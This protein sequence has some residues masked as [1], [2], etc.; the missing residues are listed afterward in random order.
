MIR[1]LRKKIVSVTMATL[2]PVILVA[3]LFSSYT[4]KK[5]CGHVI[6]LVVQQMADSGGN[7][8]EIETINDAVLGGLQIGREVLLPIVDIPI[9]I[10]TLDRW[11]AVVSVTCLT[12]E[13]ELAEETLDGILKRSEKSGS[14][15]WREC[16]YAKA[17]D[18]QGATLVIA[19]KTDNL[20]KMVR[21]K[22]NYYMLLTSLPGVVVLLLASWIFSGLAMRPAKEALEKQQQF[23]AD[24]GHELKTPLASIAVNAAALEEN[25]GRNRYLDCI[26][27]EN[28][29]LSWLVRRM[30]AAACM[31]GPEEI[32]LTQ[33]DLTSLLEQAALSY[34]AAAME[35]QIRYEFQ[36]QDD[37]SVLSDPERL[38]Q[39][40]AILLDNA[41]K[42]VDEAG[43][44]MVSLYKKGNHPVIAVGNSGPG[45]PEGD[46]PHIFDRFYRVDKARSATDSHGLGLSIASYLVRELRG[47]LSVESDPGVWTEFLLQL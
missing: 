44:V 8:V 23:L 38:R 43:T 33:V 45:I 31:E 41:F 6:D 19:E 4:V 30:I 39:I 36:I 25:I 12:G 27:Y 29:R 37:V 10:V 1:R 18:E 28:N 16:R 47:K 5:T 15:E 21:R 24:A 7:I 26:R 22:M 35:R 32:T 9:H 3:V 11:D 42:Y 46:R 2:V 14:G 20:W 40:T 17:E 34:E 13:D